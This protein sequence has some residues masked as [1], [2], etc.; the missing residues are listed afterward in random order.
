[1]DG[2]GA[3]EAV[4]APVG[5]DLAIAAAGAP[6]AQ[7]TAAAAAVDA[8]KP[9]RNPCAAKLCSAVRVRAF[10]FF[11]F[12]YFSVLCVLYIGL[13]VSLIPLKLC[14]LCFFFF[15]FLRQ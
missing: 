15:F 2:A 8:K 12:F 7:A 1:V 13:P 6:T 9:E 5:V 3:A 11:S 10:V 4:T 14:D